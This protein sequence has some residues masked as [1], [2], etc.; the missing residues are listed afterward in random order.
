MDRKVE[1]LLSKLE[2]DSYDM[3]TLISA[4]K[5]A[6]EHED[7]YERI[8]KNVIVVKDDILKVVQGLKKE[9]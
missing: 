8:L 7:D 2:V 5:D 6:I 1:R 3:L 9:L 4:L